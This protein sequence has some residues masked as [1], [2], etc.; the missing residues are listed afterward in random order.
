MR[1]R[2]IPCVGHVLSKEEHGQQK[3]MRISVLKTHAST[4]LMFLAQK[5]IIT[6]NV[7]KDPV[8]AIPRGKCVQ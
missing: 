7:K 1:L 2:Q 4:Y 3:P 5:L 8:S 6:V